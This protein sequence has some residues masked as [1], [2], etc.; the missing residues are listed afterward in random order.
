MWSQLGASI[1]M[2]ENAIRAC[3][4]DLW[5][6][7]SE[8]PE[9]NSNDVV[10]FWYVVF[11]T[12]FF[13]DLYMSD[14]LEAFVPPAPFTLDEMDPAGLLPDRPYTKEELLKYL[15][16]SRAKAR[17]AIQN[18]TEE[19]ARHQSGFQKLSRAELMLDLIRHVQHHAGQLNLLLRRHTASAPRWVKTAG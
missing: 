16:Y 13:L 19:Q 18:L 6:N 4:E 1:D 2:L 14:S 5:S 17:T 11:H 9:W 3:P 15:E 10:G 12:L 8:R 7:P